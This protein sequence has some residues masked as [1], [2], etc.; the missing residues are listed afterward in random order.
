MEV[1]RKHLQY[2]N[3]YRW[4]RDSSDSPYKRP[5]DRIKIDKQEG[6]DVL[7]FIQHMV[8]KHNI[9]NPLVVGEIEDA[10]RLPVLSGVVLSIELEMKIEQL[11]SFD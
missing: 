10:F 1:T 7:Q 6:D 4:K 3:K 2:E 11:L 9:T 5:L 8:N